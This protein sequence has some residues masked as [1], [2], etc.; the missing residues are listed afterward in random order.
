MVLLKVLK[1]VVLNSA[2]KTELILVK[3]KKKYLFRKTGKIV[4]FFVRKETCFIG[5]I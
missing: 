1:N 4:P 5:Y 2:T 3:L